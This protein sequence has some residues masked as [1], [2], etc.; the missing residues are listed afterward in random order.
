MPEV[1][2]PGDGDRKTGE[3]ARRKSERPRRDLLRRSLAPRGERRRS[4]AKQ[5]ASAF[6]SD[7]ITER[8]TCTDRYERRLQREGRKLRAIHI[9][10]GGYP[11]A[12][13]PVD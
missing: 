4:A 1:V 6:A 10:A 7:A 9:R 11:S 12:A 5:S 8:T 13:A 3:V 2:V